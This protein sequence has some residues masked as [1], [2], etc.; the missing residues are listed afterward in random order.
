MGPISSHRHI[1]RLFANI[2]KHLTILA[3]MKNAIP[4]PAQDFIE[5][6]YMAVR[7]TKQFTN[8][9]EKWKRKPVCE[10]TT[11]AQ[12]RTFFKD[13]YKFFEAERNSFHKIGVANNVVMQRN[14]DE[15]TAEMAQMRQQIMAQQAVATKYYQAID[16][17]MSMERTA[18]TDD[19][20]INL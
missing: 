12:A 15:A 17:A 3:E 10:R 16:L 8:A 4:Y 5:A 2:K 6:V 14:L 7:G 1:V 11:E 20:T 19:T 9:C 13:V 18:E